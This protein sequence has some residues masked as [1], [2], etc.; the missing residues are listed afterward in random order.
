MSN[1]DDLPKCGDCDSAA[2]SRS[3]P[4]I[5]HSIGVCLNKFSGLWDPRNCSHCLALF[6]GALK[7]SKDAEKRLKKIAEK[8][9][10]SLKRKGSTASHIFVDDE[11]AA[12]YG[13]PFFKSTIQLGGQ[14]PPSGSIEGEALSNNYDP[15]AQAVASIENLGDNATPRTP[16]HQF[17]NS[18]V[19]PPN[20]C[21]SNNSAWS[22][23]SQRD[24]GLNANVEQNNNYDQDGS[25]F[26]NNFQLGQV[27]PVPGPSRVEFDCM[28]QDMTN[29]QETMTSLLEAF[30]KRE[31]SLN[32]ALT[33][34]IRDQAP[35]DLPVPSFSMNSEAGHSRVTG[36]KPPLDPR[37][38]NNVQDDS[39]D[40]SS[41]SD[42]DS[43][44]EQDDEPSPLRYWPEFYPLTNID[45]P[46]FSR[47]N[48]GPKPPR[49]WV[50]KDQMQYITEK[51]WNSKAGFIPAHE[52]LIAGNKKEQLMALILEISPPVMSLL[53]SNW[54]LFDQVESKKPKM[55]QI[56]K[57]LPALRNFALHVPQVTDQ[58]SVD[59]EGPDPLINLKG[60]EALVKELSEVLQKDEK[61]V[62]PKLGWKMAVQDADGSKLLA[63]LQS[64]ELD[65]KAHEIPG[66]DQENLTRK[67]TIDQ[68]R[69]DLNHV[70]LQAVVC[71]V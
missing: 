53:D 29:M 70:C 40:A 52:V 15:L 62:P 55:V 19:N 48:D 22:G 16:G 7:G 42:Y 47:V 54:Q 28:R 12:T 10:G 1:S 58:W 71:L 69:L 25:N 30:K 38:N 66:V 56:S 27:N 24:Q 11:V 60:S 26:G 45:N 57:K 39:S 23:F 17:L 8:I 50:G 44:S 14:L 32:Q 67:L 4:C 61:E 59:E 63:F 36:K 65:D 33:S 68:R 18:P 34:R 9:K 43:D 20:S 35:L 5:R 3:H 49:Y 21:D 46:A 37:P 64:E 6:E 2:K 51:G 41:G 31:E 13:L